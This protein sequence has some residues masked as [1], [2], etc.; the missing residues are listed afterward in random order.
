MLPYSK[1]YIIKFWVGLMDGDGSIQI[2][3]WKKKNLQYRLVIKMKYHLNNLFMF[4]LIQTTLGGRVRIISKNLNNIYTPTF[5]IWVVDS[6][7]DFVKI[8]NVL[9]QYQPK[10]IRL[11]AQLNFAKDCLKHNNVDIY[12][13]TRKNKYII[14]EKNINN[15]SK[16]NF[17]NKTTFPQDTRFSHFFF[18]KEWL[19]GFIE[20]EGCFCKHKNNTCSFSISQQ[21]NYFLIEQIKNYFSIQSKIRILKNNFHVIETYRKESL[22]NLVEHINK[23]PL[24]GEKSISFNK[25][26]NKIK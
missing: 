20:A 11:L 22:L 9:D 3:H 5:V 2:N 10:T 1:K 14:Y 19:S 23:Y 4:N 7:K 8:L 24:L 18:F 15:N 26:K 6:K 16:P 12:L 13:N 17:V 21:D 25:L